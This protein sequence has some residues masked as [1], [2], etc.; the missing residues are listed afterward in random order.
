MGLKGYLKIVALLFVL[1]IFFSF[2]DFL[3]AQSVTGVSISIPG[4]K[5]QMKFGQRVF[6]AGIWQYVNITVDDPGIGK[7][8][9][10]FFKGDTPPD[11]DE[12]NDT[13]YY[14]WKYDD[15]T[16]GKWVDVMTYDDREY[17]QNS[18]CLKKNG[19]FSFYAKPNLFL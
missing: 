10:E 6:V 4:E 18:S 19:L 15:G 2:F 8:T 5:E 3:K 1:F 16:P 12:R 14:E 11:M 13:N 7:L 17:I 9:I